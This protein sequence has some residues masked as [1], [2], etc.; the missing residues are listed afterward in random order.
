M[1][2]TSCYRLQQQV[3]APPL[4]ARLLTASADIKETQKD[5]YHTLRDVCAIGSEGCRAP[6]YLVQWP[7]VDNG[8]GEAA[9]PKVRTRCDASGRIGT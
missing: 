3:P 2:L 8:L 9:F 1:A 4:A 6:G 7:Y 5:Y